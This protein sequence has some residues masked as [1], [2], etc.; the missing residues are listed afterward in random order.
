MNELYKCISEGSGCLLKWFDD[1]LFSSALH[2]KPKVSVFNRNTAL[3]TELKTNR[4]NSAFL[5]KVPPAVREL[6]YRDS[7]CLCAV[8][9]WPKT[10]QI[11]MPCCKF[12][13][14]SEKQAYAHSTHLNNSDKSSRIIYGADKIHIIVY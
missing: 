3:S 12:W 14:V 13:P 7:Y 8:S 10:D 1:I 11:Y 9:V 2:V 5:Y 4:S 6:I